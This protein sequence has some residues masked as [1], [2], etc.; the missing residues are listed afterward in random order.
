MEIVEASPLEKPE[1]RKP[2]EATVKVPPRKNGGARGP[3]S[4][5]PE[6]SARPVSLASEPVVSQP[7]P[8][9]P[10]PVPQPLPP[11]PPKEAS[12]RRSLI[13]ETLDEFLP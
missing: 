7:E 12:P 6:P 10:E 11:A 2:K 13:K 5:P 8:T 1:S 4:S 3:K 9:A